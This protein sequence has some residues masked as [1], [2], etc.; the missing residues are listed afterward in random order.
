MTDRPMDPSVQQKP[1]P[2]A[3]ESGAPDRPDDESYE[4]EIEA[5]ETG[6]TTEG[7]DQDVT[8]EEDPPDVAYQPKSG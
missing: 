4:E 8:D 1:P 7:L 5:E 2:L 6:T 3:Y